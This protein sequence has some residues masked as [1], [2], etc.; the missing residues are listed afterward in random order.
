MEKQVLA[1]MTETELIADKFDSQAQNTEILTRCSYIIKN[2]M[3]A[4]KA[5]SFQLA[6][7][8]NFLLEH[9]GEY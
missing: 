9:A 2:K 7:F 1:S 6:N 4:C 3:S 5:M 8:G